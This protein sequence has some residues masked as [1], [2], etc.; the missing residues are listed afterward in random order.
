MEA[1]MTLAEVFAQPPKIGCFHPD[2]NGPVLW[3]QIHTNRG[4]ISTCVEHRPEAERI[5][6]EAGAFVRGRTF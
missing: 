2:C 4:T 6:R 1:P 3:E 5:V